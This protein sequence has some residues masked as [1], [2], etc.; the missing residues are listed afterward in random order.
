MKKILLSLMLTA[1]AFTAQAAI[2][3]H[4]KADAAPYIWAW[5]NSGNVFSESWP[6]HQFTEKKTVKDTEFWYYTFD[7]SI[8]LVNILFN[9]G[10]ATGPV[11]QTGDISG[12]TTDR[13]FEYDG[14]NTFTDVTEQFGGE[15][16]D[17][18]VESLTLRSNKNNS[19]WS[20]DELVFT[21]VEPNK[22][23]GV[24]DLTENNISDGYWQFKIR[25]NGQG[26]VGFSK[27]N[28]TAPEWCEQARSDDN[29]QID[30]ESELL[31][32]LV[33]SFT[34]T[35]AGGKNAEEGWSLVI[36]N[37]NSTDVSGIKVENNAS[38]TRYNLQGQ[39]IG[40]NYR[41]IMVING[42][43]MIKK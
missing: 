1:M 11:K 14:A 27:V 17:A 7:E 33:F 28:L 3:I 16:P 15:I 43:K 26:W 39:R 13:Y 38:Q 22:F 18:K 37:A 6:G 35:W 10:G 32:S 24:F 19:D 25:P 41:G 36:E 31:T 20:G 8:T 40:A 30:L 29:F 21:M 42:K 23:V 34:A 2:T 12:I 4:V 9:D 5:T